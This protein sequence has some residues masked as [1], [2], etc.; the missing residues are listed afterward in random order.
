[1]LQLFHDHSFSFTALPFKDV[2]KQDGCRLTQPSGSHHI[3]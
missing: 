2:S 1:M 3:Y